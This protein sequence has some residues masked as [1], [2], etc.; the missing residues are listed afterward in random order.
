MTVPV[1]LPA[2]LI[3]VTLGLMVGA[4]IR[5]RVQDRRAQG[6]RGAAVTQRSDPVTE[7]DQTAPRP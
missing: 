5:F 4:L 2:A 7:E 6:G 3:V 1:L